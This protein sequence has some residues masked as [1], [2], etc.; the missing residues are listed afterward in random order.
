M[1]LQIGSADGFLTDSFALVFSLPLD[2]F[3]SIDAG[4]RALGYQPLRVRPYEAVGQVAVAA[5][6]SRGAPEGRVSLRLKYDEISKEALIQQNE[7]FELVDLSGFF[8]PEDGRQRPRHAAFFRKSAKPLVPQ[9]YAEVQSGKHKEAYQALSGAGLGP[10]TLV[11]YM[12]PDGTILVDGVWSH[13]DRWKFNWNTPAAF[14]QVVE[15]AATEYDQVDATI[16][17]RSTGDAGDDRFWSGV[18][19][20][21]G[22]FESQAIY[23]L[24]PKDQ[25]VKARELASAGWQPI[26]AAATKLKTKRIVTAALWQRPWPREVRATFEQQRQAEAA[27]KSGDNKTAVSLM[28]D[29]VDVRKRMLGPLHPQTRQALAARASC[30][31]WLDRWNDAADDLLLA[32]A[33]LE[34]S[35]YPDRMTANKWHNDIDEWL[36]WGVEDA[37][38]SEMWSTAAATA[39]RRKDVTRKYFGPNHWRSQNAAEVTDAIRARL[40]GSTGFRKDL[41][42]ADLLAAKVQALLRVGRPAEALPHAARVIEL[43][44]RHCDAGSRDVMEARLLSAQVLVAAAHPAEAVRELD[45]AVGARRGAKR[46]NDPLVGK[47]LLRQ[48]IALTAIDDHMRAAR[49]SLKGAELLRDAYG[50]KSQ[51]TIDAANSAALCVARIAQMKHKAAEFQDAA[52][53][54]KIVSDFY[55][56]LDDDASRIK[57]R[58]AAW[59]D[60][61]DRALAAASL[62]IRKR[63]VAT[64]GALKRV[65]E[66]REQKPTE[67][68]AAA[69]KLLSTVED[70]TGHDSPSVADARFTIG[71]L[72]EQLGQM[73]EAMS[74]FRSVFHVYE[75]SVG[76][77]HPQ[78]REAADRLV[79]V[80]DRL[81]KDADFEVRP[82]DAVRYLDDILLI[83]RQ[84]FGEN[85]WKT[86]V[87]RGALTDAKR[88]QLLSAQLREELRMA[89]GWCRQALRANSDNQPDVALARIAQ[90]VRVYRRLLGDDHSDTGYGERQMAAFFDSQGNA[91]RA[92]QLIK[93]EIER[94]ERRFGTTYP[95]FAELS[96]GLA[97]L[98]QRLEEY[99]SAAATL[100]RA[101]AVDAAL[102]GTASNQYQ[103]DVDLLAQVLTV[104][105]SRQKASGNFAAAASLVG[106]IAS[107]YRAR[108]GSDNWQTIEA[109]ATASELRDWASHPAF[110]KADAEASSLLDKASGRDQARDFDAVFDLAK[111][112]EASCRTA[113]VAASR[114]LALAYWW[115]GRAHLNLKRSEE[116]ARLLGKAAEMY[117]RVYG[118]AHPSTL[119]LEED[120]ATLDES[121]GNSSAAAD[122]LRAAIETAHIAQSDVAAG[123][124]A[125]EFV[126]LLERR[127]QSQ[128][129][130][131]D[132]EGARLTLERAIKV[133]DSEFGASNYRAHRLRERRDYAQL[134]AESSPTRRHRLQSAEATCQR[135]W[136]DYR[137]GRLAPAVDGYKSAHSVIVA[138]L[139]AN[140]P[141]AA[142]IAFQVGWISRERGDHRMAEEW[143]V[144][145]LKIREKTLPVG[146]VDLAFSLNQLGHLYR[147]LD[148]PKR[149]EGLYRQALPIL[150]KTYGS[151]HEEVAEALTNI[152]LVLQDQGK[153]DE[154]GVQLRQ[155]RSIYE[156]RHRPVEVATTDNH[157][158][159]LASARR[160]FEEAERL[161][162]S[163]ADVHRSN[164]PRSS[165]DYALSLHNLGFVYLE[166]GKFVDAEP[167]LTEALRLRRSLTGDAHRDTALTAK[168]L[169]RAHVGLKH[170]SGDD[171]K[172]AIASGRSTANYGAADLFRAQTLAFAGDLDRA[173]DELRALWSNRK[174]ALGSEHAWTASAC[175]NLIG[176]LDRRAKQNADRDNFAAAARDFT[177]AADL[178]NS[179][180][181]HQTFRVVALR[182]MAKDQAKAAALPVAAQS[183][184]TAAHARSRR[185]RDLLTNDRP[186]DA[187]P[188]FESAGHVYALHLGDRCH[189]HALL[190]EQ[191]AHAA[192]RAE[193][194]QIA[195]TKFLQAIA[196]Y[197]GLVGRRHLMMAAPLLGLAHVRWSQA[198]YLQAE[199]LYREAVAIYRELNLAGDPGYLDALNGLAA[200]V[201]EL[202]NS[203]AA[204][205][206]MQEALEQ[207]R[208][209]SGDRNIK[210][211]KVLEVRASLEQSSGDFSGAKADLRQAIEI[212]AGVNDPDTV[213]P[214]R[215][216]AGILFQTNE[217]RE[218][219]TLQRE[220]LER[221][222]RK[223]RADHPEVRTA[224]ADLSDV[225]SQIATRHFDHGDYSESARYWQEVGELRSSLYGA[226]NWRT[227]NARTARRRAT[228]FATAAP[229]A[230]KSGLEARRHSQ[231]ARRAD[232]EKRYADAE[233]LER[234]AIA[235]LQPVLGADHHDVAAEYD[236]L[237][238]SLRLQQKLPE[239][240]DAIRTAIAAA[241]SSLGE[242]H[243]AT[244]SYIGHLALIR[245]TRGDYEDGIKLRR[246][247]IQILI[248]VRGAGSKEVIAATDRLIAMLDARVDELKE[249]RNFVRAGAAIGE[250]RTAMVERYG[251]ANWRVADVDHRDRYLHQLAGMQPAQQKAAADAEIIL[252][253]AIRLGDAGKHNE[254]LAKAR[255]AASSIAR[256]FGMDSR[257]YAQAAE[258]EG[259][260]AYHLKQLQ[261]A[262]QRLREATDIMGRLAGPGH[263]ET[264]GC[265]WWLA[266]CY[267]KE[268]ARAR[269]AETYERAYRI[270][271]TA[272]GPNSNETK[273]TLRNLFDVFESIANE[274][275]QAGQ[276]ADARPPREQLVALSAKL[277]G[278]DH[279]RT[280]GF[281]ASAAAAERRARLGSDDRHK[282]SDALRQFEQYSP[283]TFLSDPQ[284]AVLTLQPLLE[285]TEA[286]IG[287]N[288]PAVID[289]YSVL[290]VAAEAAGDDAAAEGF[291]KRAEECAAATWGRSHP[292]YADVLQKYA[293][294]VSMPGRSAAIIHT[295]LLIHKQT[296]A[297]DV[298]YAR[299]VVNYAHALLRLGLDEAARRELY[300]AARIFA[301]NGQDK[302]NEY[303]MCLKMV[304]GLERVNGKL[305]V[306]GD[307]LT[308]SIAVLEGLPESDRD[309]LAEAYRFRAWAHR[310]AKRAEEAVADLQR[311]YDLESESWGPRSLQ[312]LEVRTELAMELL[313]AGK[314]HEAMAHLRPVLDNFREAMDP[315]ARDSDEHQA[316]RARHM[317]TALD[318]WL[319]LVRRGRVS[320]VDA[321]RDVLAWK[322]SL[323]AGQQRVRRDQIKQP[324]LWPDLD[325][326]DDL[327]RKVAAL[328]F[329]TSDDRKRP[330]WENERIKL[331]NERSDMIRKLARKND[332]FRR[333]IERDALDAT[334]VSSVL[335]P[336]TV[337]IDI[338]ILDDPIDRALAFVLRKGSNPVLLDFGSGNALEVLIERWRKNHGLGAE[339]EAAALELKSRVWTKILPYLGSAKILLV[340][341][342]GAFARLPLGALPGEEPETY[343]I[344]SGLSF[345]VVP[346]PRLLP[347]LLSHAPGRFQAE[348]AEG[349]LLVGDV[350]YGAD[351]GKP[352]SKK[353]MIRAVRDGEESFA[354]L[355]ATKL[356][357][358]GVAA[359]FTSSTQARG[360]LKDLRKAEATEASV[361]DAAGRF[362]YYH[363][364][365]HGF[366]HHPRIKSNSDH[367][368]GVHLGRLSGIVLSGANRATHDFRG[369]VAD[370]GILTALEV[371]ELDF[372]TARLVVLS[373][374][375]TGLGSEENGDGVLGMQRAFQV[376]GA[377]TC[378]ASL[379]KVDDSAT[380]AL[381]HSFYRRLWMDGVTP[382]DA[383]RQSQLDLLRNYRYDYGR[384][385]LVPR[386]GAGRQPLAKRPTKSPSLP[387]AF[388]GA[389]VISGDWR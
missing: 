149:A 55:T 306:A 371:A 80:L 39:Q 30:L 289:R 162:K 337:L 310:Q 150:T 374:C 24:S 179:T 71:R 54:W 67:Q 57:A 6:W 241:R 99:D 151:E 224:R 231:E 40:Q 109:L 92:L 21:R 68:V 178:L 249:R 27:K 269:A 388:W 114:P 152:G 330:R 104:L 199:N 375:D 360:R 325:R 320:V 297:E 256:T 244:A 14:S 288:N 331:I 286:L 81:A 245:A 284:K 56:S 379:W 50:A 153:V 31:T 368:P 144:K 203:E 386:G 380:Q 66:Q 228:A 11:P 303:A 13:T 242:A 285:T 223:D 263:P 61:E 187:L 5:I 272:S 127:A 298:G 172:F 100:R 318:A 276:F 41:R 158:G 89:N 134:F 351:P 85:H 182:L 115:Q 382:L 359:L 175:R 145:A 319:E 287:S 190:V 93:R 362:A 311:A 384:L 270:F 107:L 283:K 22:N 265:L 235:A 248:K 174:T 350:D 90:A 279:W 313:Q 252:A 333:A 243:D 365:T 219:E 271:L 211:A 273:S 133:A 220:V 267:L 217:L 301:A 135:A 180:R 118:P 125:N 142:T 29:V 293:H 341:P 246:Q 64:M 254:S 42:E 146:H 307:L 296:M 322:G 113:N 336:Q 324:E 138:E 234:A 232:R 58:D 205:R 275:E 191:A 255:I 137:A 343:L 51:S 163:A 258:R 128:L 334:T 96:R 72:H 17:T 157:L 213:I 363:F 186:A 218:A 19:R 26:A 317:K 184:L 230:L 49:S 308:R 75:R 74:A 260:S 23:N 84:R 2:R 159:L 201:N 387:L 102:Y 111:K 367:E 120:R 123:E 88:T 240:E 233:R 282:L 193:R 36:E 340:S 15:E 195:E 189:A 130:K 1:R 291:A 356:E 215:Q 181:G 141:I 12:R 385:E 222:S 377:Q 346:A 170:A 302:S 342:H 112:A 98:Y 18:W 361:R 47:A 131:S 77:D 206:L 147:M 86:S 354:A 227:V 177:E 37:I 239:A 305:K 369:S 160:D 192:R 188:L 376:A 132:L 173:I 154:A 73:S 262:E 97:Q 25:V 352:S 250:W 383:L 204:K 121:R 253:D 52:S 329:A 358:D 257:E 198:N 208:V 35:P 212:R 136:S 28:N 290:A 139:S 216:L 167:V 4:M 366:E 299:I 105:Q 119:R 277:L 353:P 338:V 314:D 295:A 355:P 108:H 372:S 140:H 344:E 101:M 95:D 328:E 83:R 65:D 316:H 259:I 43:R 3:P 7:G 48:S 225:L 373:A 44:L 339:A 171:V 221:R 53:W 327:T 33:S 10:S 129:A 370:D 176:A 292:M 357:V 117:A 274:A 345:V 194:L 126:D 280:V 87:A 60:R 348:S 82:E 347:E 91:A 247:A 122:R 300:A 76:I 278:A 378:I 197:E 69:E 168:L 185:A 251:A 196:I 183:E 304:G 226:G 236:M 166:Q 34:Q 20:R 229:A 156:A 32:L 164:L 326:L 165:G 8:T 110:A 335:P 264:A 124:L 45:A 294:Y 70:A 9:W 210:F 207:A 266:T 364:A 214:L 62:D 59:H 169:A 237:A 381:M 155:A 309:G 94:I 202:G 143:L 315:G 389:F 148:E 116:A 321:Y 312:T 63:Y 238:R 261:L 46:G 323:F 79:A 281:R 349:L 78:T 332:V 16:C 103:T 161:L 106:E 200:T 268:G 209:V 38:Q